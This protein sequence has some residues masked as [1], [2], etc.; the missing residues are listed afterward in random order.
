MTIKAGNHFDKTAKPV[1]ILPKIK[2]SIDFCVILLSNRYTAIVTNEKKNTSIWS[3]AILPAVCSMIN[4]LIEN[5]NA[6]IK[7]TFVESK[8]LPILKV[9]NIER[10]LSNIEGSLNAMTFVPKK[11]ILIAIE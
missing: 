10:V 1:R 11:Y 7:P 5:K 6:A 8:I 4:P 2:D 3:V 9:A